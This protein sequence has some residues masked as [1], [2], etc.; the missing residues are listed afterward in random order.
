MPDERQSITHKFSIAGH[1]GY[2]TV[3][4]YEDGTPGEVFLSMS[5][6]GT[7][8]SGLVDSIAIAI[9]L[10][11]QHG[12]PLALLVE[13]YSHT[14]FEPS[15]FTGNP[16]I[17]MAKSILD[18]VFRWLSIK[19]LTPM[20]RKETELEAQ[21]PTISTELNGSTT[22]SRTLGDTPVNQLKFTFAAQ[23]DAPPCSECGS[24]EV[25]R[26]GACYKC[27]NCGASMGCS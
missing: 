27:L 20:E 24:I 11:L 12:V 17:P 1:E 19:F 26:N 14:R 8:V 2:I 9:S 6:E 23:T 3:G 22:A 15:G 16:Q 4:M 5:K 13:K 25:V 10:S 21:K 7:V 18:Y